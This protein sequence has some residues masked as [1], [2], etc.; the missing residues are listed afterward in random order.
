MPYM[1][2]Q[3]SIAQLV[4]S[5]IYHMCGHMYFLTRNSDLAQVILH[6][7]ITGPSQ[8]RWIITSNTGKTC[9]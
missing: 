8:S 1:A 3:H 7:I 9:F 2:L 4:L 6:L 5:Q